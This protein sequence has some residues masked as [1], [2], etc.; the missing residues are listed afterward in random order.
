VEIAVRTGSPSD[1]PS[2]YEVDEKNK[3]LG[4]IPEKC[5]TCVVDDRSKVILV[6]VPSRLP[7]VTCQTDTDAF[8]F[9]VGCY[10]SSIEAAVER[11]AKS[12]SVPALGTR[13]HRWK[14]LQSAAAARKAIESVESWAPDDFRV[15]FAVGDSLDDAN[16]WDRV[17]TF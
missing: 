5:G 9:L 13:H 2:D 6:T 15:T 11:G 10:L 4:P 14:H 8:C 3:A 12:I 7:G 1:Y 17:L 16:A